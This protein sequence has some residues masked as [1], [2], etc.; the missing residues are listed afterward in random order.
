MKK[1]ETMFTCP[2]CGYDVFSEPPGHYEICPICNW[3]DDISQLKFVETL[4]A[5]EVSLLQAQDNFKNFG[6]SERHF[7]SH[8]KRGDNTYA[9]NP[10]WRMFDVEIDKIVDP[11]KDKDCGGDY[12]TD[13][14][15]LYYWTNSSKKAEQ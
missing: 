12:P 3:E 9:K 8:E 4:G 6:A 5:N 2:C 15:K 11:Q 7:I 14:T 13:S 10:S 1:D